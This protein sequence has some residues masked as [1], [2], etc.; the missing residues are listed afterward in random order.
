M[1]NSKSI[2][3][4]WTLAQKHLC[5]KFSSY[6][7]LCPLLS[8]FWVLNKN[9]HLFQSFHFSSAT[10]S[11]QLFPLFLTVFLTCPSHLH[12]GQPL[13]LFPSSQYSSACLGILKAF[14]LLMWP[15]HLILPSS[16]S[17]CILS[18]FKISLIL[19]LCIPP[20]LVFPSMLLKN[21]I[22][23]PWVLLESFFAIL[24]VLA[25]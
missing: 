11:I 18:N 8:R 25:P 15:Y 7:I 10:I 17:A 23:V 22:S 21:L 9:L 19:M 2:N 1:E 4:W 12:L 3:L 13:G 5:S 14:I 20:H 24:H 6:L 16:I